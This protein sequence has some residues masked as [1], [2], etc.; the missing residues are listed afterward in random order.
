MIRDGNHTCFYDAENRLVQV[1]PPGTTSVNCSTATA[2]YLYDAL[3]R[4][5]RKS[6]AGVPLTTDYVYD[7]R[8]NVVAEMAPPR[9]WF[10]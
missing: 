9:F 10:V 8:G 5:V 2:C 3:G 7:L 6:G 4:R 1:A